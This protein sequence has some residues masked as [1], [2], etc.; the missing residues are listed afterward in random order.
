MNINKKED[1]IM[2]N[3]IILFNSL[4]ARVFAKSSSENP[5]CSI[6]I[7]KPVHT[8]N[9]RKPKSENGKFFFFLCVEK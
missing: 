7:A 8:S 6:Y 4:P 1:I 3:P 2:A 5:F 9:A